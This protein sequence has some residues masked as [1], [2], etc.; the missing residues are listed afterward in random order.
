VA[1]ILVEAGTPFEEALAAVTTR[2]AAFFGFALPQCTPDDH[3]A[4]D[5]RFR[6]RRVV[7]GGAVLFEDPSD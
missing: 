4:I 2:P 6:L 1:Q 3:V 5:E 7:R